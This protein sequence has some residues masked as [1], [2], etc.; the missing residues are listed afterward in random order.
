M[1]QE[2][3]TADGGQRVGHGCWEMASGWGLQEA[4]TTNVH[5]ERTKPHKTGRNATKILLDLG[6]F[7]QAK[8]ITQL[9]LIN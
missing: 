6:H 8:M 9:C 7:S 2:S 4:V 3:S 5:S 1:L